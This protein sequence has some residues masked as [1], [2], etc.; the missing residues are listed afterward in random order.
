MSE[1][2]HEYFLG[3]WLGQFEGWWFHYLKDKN[4]DASAR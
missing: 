4:A 2:N 3:Y 1:R